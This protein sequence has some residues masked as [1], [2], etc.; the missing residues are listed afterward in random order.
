MSYLKKKEK[1]YFPLEGKKKVLS[2]LLYGFSHQPGNLIKRDL[3][4]KFS[5][6]C[7][8]LQT[9][10]S[11]SIYHYVA[12]QWVEMEQ[13]QIFVSC[14]KCV[15]H[16]ALFNMCNAFCLHSYAISSPVP[17]DQSSKYS[18]LVGSRNRYRMHSN[19]L[20]PRSILNWPCW[21]RELGTWICHSLCS[22]INLFCFPLSSISPTTLW[23]HFSLLLLVLAPVSFLCFLTV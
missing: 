22:W 4:K 16:R 8:L 11:G 1:E 6:G 5:R 3:E 9:R 13:M 14:T 19:F 2:S 15:L 17:K 18:V 23:P 10:H 12:V 20:S 7:S 21:L